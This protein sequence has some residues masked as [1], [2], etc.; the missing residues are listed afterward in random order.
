METIYF[1]NANMCITICEENQELADIFWGVTY[2][3]SVP[4]VYFYDN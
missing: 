3:E 4:Y 2:Q 1:D